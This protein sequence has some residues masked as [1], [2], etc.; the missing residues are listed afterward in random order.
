MD[1]K[2]E[3]EKIFKM[4]YTKCLTIISIKEFMDEI[5]KNVNVVRNNVPIVL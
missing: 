5:K 1:F 2:K 3:S 4:H